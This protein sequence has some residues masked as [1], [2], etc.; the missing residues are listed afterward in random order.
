MKPRLIVIRILYNQIE[1]PLKKILS[2]RVLIELNK[3]II[4]NGFYN[5]IAAVV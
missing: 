5:N 1:M 3:N 4:S 2:D